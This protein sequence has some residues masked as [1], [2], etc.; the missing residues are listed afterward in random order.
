M[1]ETQDPELI[2]RAQA[3]DPAAFEA[4]VNAYYEV[5]FKMAFKWCGRR[6]DAEDITQEACIR[7]A[8]GIGSFNHK[9]AFTS[10]LY[11][12]VINAAKDF[13]RKRGGQPESADNP[14]Y[15]NAADGA[16][17]EDALYARQVWDEVYKLPEGEKEALL[18]V[19][20]EGLSHKEAAKLAGVKESTISWRVHE[21]RK[22]L[23]EIF[24]KERS[25]G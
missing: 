10:W 21:A 18:L 8:R 19:M 12:L 24:G 9:S 16:N 5:M 2:K 13:Y 20:A 4:L 6:D 14:G 11:V 3:G 25:Y 1:A 15:I 23:A 7:V 22:K 17:A